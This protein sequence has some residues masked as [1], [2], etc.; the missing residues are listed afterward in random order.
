MNERKVKL[1]FQKNELPCEYPFEDDLFI[2]DVKIKLT[3]F[4]IDAGEI[5]T[6]CKTY[7]SQLSKIFISINIL[8]VLIQV[9]RLRGSGL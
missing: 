4:D 3:C 8:R 5:S 6:R 7:F 1:F 2:W 9:A